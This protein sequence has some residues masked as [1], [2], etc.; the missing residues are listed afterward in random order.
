MYNLG[1]RTDHDICLSSF[2]LQNL[3]I[4]EVAQDDSDIG[5]C[6]LD[7]LCLF[8]CADQGR[9]LV[10]GVFVVERVE[11]VAA[12]VPCCS[13]TKS[14]LNL[15]KINVDAT[16]MNILGA[17]FKYCEIVLFVVEGRL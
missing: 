1:G 17:M 3:C 4:F 11:S 2:L 7:W 5:K 16:Y 12:D 6:F 9:V 10:V 13:G 8:F 14:L 15:L